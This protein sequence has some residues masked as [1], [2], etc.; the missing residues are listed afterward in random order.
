MDEIEIRSSITKILDGHYRGQRNYDVTATNLKNLYNAIDSQ[1]Q[2]KFFEP[3]W[4]DLVYQLDRGPLPEMQGVCRYPSVIRVVMRV[5]AD[6]GPIELFA[7]LFGHINFGNPAVLKNWD[8]DILDEMVIAIQ[9]Y[10]DRF[11][12]NMLDELK[13]NA[14]L[15]AGLAESD[16]ICVEV[17]ANLRSNFVRLQETIERIEFERFEKALASKASQNVRQPETFSNEEELSKYLNNQG[18]EMSIGDA[19]REAR[20]YLLATGTFDPK[21]AADLIRSSIEEMHR[22]I[23]STLVNLTGE[24][25][26]QKNSDGGRRLYMRNANFISL[27]EETFFSAIYTLISEEATHKLVA[28][29]ETVLLLEQTVSGYLL[30]LARR[31]SDWRIQHPNLTGSS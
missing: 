31:L 29:K 24:A 27:A 18:L 10:P 4:L 6:F 11:S 12:Q 23:V 22:G 26:T 2:S 17:P 1:S 8:R 21:K 5:I 28:P 20:E 16:M 9:R 30:L 7:Q 14:A 13:R 19:M 15:N 3:L 25:F